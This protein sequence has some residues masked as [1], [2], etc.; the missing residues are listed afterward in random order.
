[1]SAEI[2]PR[3]DA[4]WTFPKLVEIDDYYIDP[5]TVVAEWEGTPRCLSAALM[6]AERGW[7][8]FPVPPGTKKSYVSPKN[9]PNHNG[10]RWGA[11][12]DPIL[13]QEYS[14]MSL[15]ATRARN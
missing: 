2:Q 10:K 11:T 14:N 1:M 15:R 13:I 4:Q 12:N 6:Y 9:Y 7:H 5:D 8:V 3:A